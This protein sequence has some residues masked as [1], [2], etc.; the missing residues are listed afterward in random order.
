[1]TQLPTVFRP[2]VWPTCR[3]MKRYFLYFGGSVYVEKI[4]LNRESIFHS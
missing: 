1:M 3:L 2:P 4:T